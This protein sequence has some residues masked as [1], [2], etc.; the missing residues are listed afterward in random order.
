MSCQASVVLFET[1]QTS[2]NPVHEY[3]WYMYIN[4]HPR[5]VVNL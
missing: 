1:Q 2:D 3:G 5:R 4:W